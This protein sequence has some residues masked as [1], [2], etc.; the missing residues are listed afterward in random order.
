MAGKLLSDSFTDTT[1]Y[2]DEQWEQ[3]APHLGHHFRDELLDDPAARSQRAA[4]RFPSPNALPLYALFRDA[5]KDWAPYTV[6]CRDLSETGIGVYHGMDV[7]PETR[8]YILFK[9]RGQSDKILGRVKYCAD[10]VGRVK[11]LGIQFDQPIDMGIY[12]PLLQSS[13]TRDTVSDSV[14]GMIYNEDETLEES[15]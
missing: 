11:L 5:N 15:A 6:R 4:M 12:L 9:E 2:T 10:L 3:V 14:A 1:G 7:E 13:P 8:C